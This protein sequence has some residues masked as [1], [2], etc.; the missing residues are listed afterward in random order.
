M[1]SENKDKRGGKRPQGMTAFIVVWVG[2]LVSLLGTSMTNFALTI[3]VYGETGQATDL[4]LVGF[5]YTVPLL[6]LSPFAGAL[7]DRSNRKL[8]MIVSDA[9][10]GFATIMVLILFSTGY[11]EI[12]HLYVSAAISGASQTVQWPAYSASISTMIPKELYGRAHGLNSLS[13]NGSRIFAPILAAALLGFVGIRT[14]LWIDVVTFTFAISTLLFVVIP[15]PE[16]TEEGAKS[17]GSFLAESMFGFYYIWQRKSLLGLQ[18]VFLCGNFFASLAYTL[19]A[20]MILARTG[21]D[22]ILL[23][24][25]QSVGA[26]GGVV[27]GLVMSAWGGPKKLVHGV[28]LG[29]FFSG[30]ALFLMGFGQV[31]L[32]WAAASF[33]SAFLI[34]PLNGS[35]QAIWQKK[36]PADLQGRVF[37]I[38]RLIAWL[39]NPIAML[40]AGPLADQVMEPAM[41]VGG[42][43]VGTLGGW[44]GSGPGCGD[45]GDCGC[46]WV[47]GGRLRT[48]SL[49]LSCCA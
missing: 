43:L 21:N 10:A 8:M 42:S 2:Q 20:P 16:K 11:L 6:A 37:S 25:V 36:V 49:C 9:G 18:L 31:W 17:E 39:I 33:I 13:G 45:G 22:E 32:I 1:V 46:G 41:M 40:I 27:G 3:W 5:F 44:F 12:W 35:N 29:W 26:V 47:G 38:R 28:F 23:G 30:V 24:S 48:G 4:A 19:V 7:V 15:Q 14:I 34:P